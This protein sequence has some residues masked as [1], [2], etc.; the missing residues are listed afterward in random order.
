M[1]L[2]FAKQKIKHSFYFRTQAARHKCH[3]AYRAT[4][5]YVSARKRHGMTATPL[6]VLPCTTFPISA[7]KRHGI[8]ATPLIV[9][10]CLRGPLA[11]VSRIRSAIHAE[12]FFFAKIFL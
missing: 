10:P 8:T 9:L 4:V 7:R 5:H 6:I 11:L 2:D 3:A 12:H 1:S